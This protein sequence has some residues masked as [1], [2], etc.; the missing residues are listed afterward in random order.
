MWGLVCH[1]G[2][3]GMFSEGGDSTSTPFLHLQGFDLQKDPQRPALACPRGPFWSSPFP[4][5]CPRAWLEPL[6]LVNRR[7]F[8]LCPKRRGPR[9]CCCL[10]SE[11]LRG[12]EGR[13]PPCGGAR[14]L[15]EGHSVGTEQSWP[16]CSSSAVT[17]AGPSTAPALTLDQVRSHCWEGWSPW[18]HQGTVTLSER[19]QT[20]QHLWSHPVL[21]W[22]AARPSSQ[23]HAG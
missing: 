2:L 20:H 8:T 14:W 16:R 9:G 21:P 22:P 3:W 19:P 7:S 12:A 11:R 23:S 4:P 15:L 5:V 13:C 18:G 10:G 1:R 17:A 6:A